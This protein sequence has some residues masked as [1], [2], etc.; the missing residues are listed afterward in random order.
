L[1]LQNRKWMSK[2]RAAIKGVGGYVPDH[3]LSNEDLAKMVDT[4]DEWIVSRTGIK[5]RRIINDP[6]VGTS[7]LGARAVLNLI[8]KTGI[9]PNE[10]ELLI[11]ATIKGDMPVPDTANTILDK[12]G[13]KNAWGF[14]INAAC[15]GFLFAL[16]TASQFIETGRH[17][18]VVVVGADVMSSVVNY[19]DRTTCI[20]FGDGAGAVLLEANDEGYGLR[21]SVL[22][23]DGS[24][25]NL[26]YIKG[27]GTLYP[28]TEDFIKTKEQYIYQDGKSVFKYAVNGMSGAIRELMDRN[29]LTKSDISWIVPHQANK[30]IINA[31]GES[32]DFPMERVMTNII[33]YGNTTAATLPLCLWDYEK[34][35]VKGDNL[36]FTA[37]GGGFT[38][39]ATYLRW[40]Y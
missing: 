25:R 39:G 21:D 15:S 19:E 31:I 18:K 7:D 5:E 12:V 11:C 13:A 27:G 1:R 14:D 17:K 26:L 32:L 38:W 16:T 10:I 22:K 8:E 9:D 40:A 33:R 20:L 36:L 6:K 2:V 34:Q 24:G 28:M 4:S 37:F 23:G 35:L 29:D 30:R 3:I